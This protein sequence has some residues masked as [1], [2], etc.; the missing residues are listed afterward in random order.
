MWEIPEDD[1]KVLILRDLGAIIQ[2]RESGDMYRYTSYLEMIES[3]LFDNLDKDYYDKKL[4]LLLTSIKG[5]IGEFTN[6]S[7]KDLSDGG[8]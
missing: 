8:E 6:K 5:E 1:L 7:Y 4:D 3:L 2:F